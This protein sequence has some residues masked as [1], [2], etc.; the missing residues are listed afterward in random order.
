MMINFQMDAKLPMDIFENVMQLAIEGCKAIAQYIREV[1]NHA[2]L[3]CLLYSPSCLV[4]IY[5]PYHYIEEEDMFVMHLFHM[6]ADLESTIPLA[7]GT[8]LSFIP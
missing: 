6:M 3:F 7:G 8:C 5:F 4:T 1:R 2:T